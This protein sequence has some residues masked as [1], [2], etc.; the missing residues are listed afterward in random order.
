VFLGVRPESI[1]VRGEGVDTPPR[2]ASWIAAS[3]Y[4]QEPLGSD[5][6]LTLDIGGAHVKARTSPDLALRAGDRVE[7][8]FEPG[9]L[10]LFDRESG[11]SLVN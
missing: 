9:R 10:H 4:I 6:F 11:T 7:V 3:V 8:A 2:G 1:V 5:L